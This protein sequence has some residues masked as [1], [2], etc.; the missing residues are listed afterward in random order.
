M[1]RSS[2]PRLPRVEGSA[3]N[4]ADRVAGGRVWTGR[5]AQARGLI[6]S[7]GGTEE[8]IARACE[9]AKISRDRA[10]IVAYSPKR[11]LSDCR[12]RGSVESARTLVSGGEPRSHRGSRP[13]RICSSW[14]RGFCGFVSGSALVRSRASAS[15][16]TALAASR[17][18]GGRGLRSPRSARAHVATPR[19]TERIEAIRPTSFA[20]ARNGFLRPSS[21]DVAKKSRS[22]APRFECSEPPA[23]RRGFATA[24]SRP[25]SAFAIRGNPFEEWRPTGSSGRLPAARVE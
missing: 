8:A 21:F 22:K 3:R 10:R 5:Q 23:V 6:D 18:G 13:G 11:R 17:G 16:L 15:S 20:R 9:L 4:E 24:S 19:S 1:K 14:S 12:P 7:L 2:C 25:T